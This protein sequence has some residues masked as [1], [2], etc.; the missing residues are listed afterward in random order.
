LVLKVVTKIMMK[1]LANMKEALDEAG[2]LPFNNCYQQFLYLRGMDG[3]D[4]VWNEKLGG[5]CIYSARVLKGMLE[6]IPGC[7]AD[8]LCSRTE[9][10]SGKPAAHI[11]VVAEFDGKQYLMD[12]F[13]MHEEPLC[14]TDVLE[15]GH[16]AGSRAQ[17]SFNGQKT[18]IALTPHFGEGLKKEFLLMRGCPSEK[19]ETEMDVMYQFHMDD[20]GAFGYEDGDEALALS[21]PG[22]CIQRVRIGDRVLNVCFKTREDELWGEVFDISY[23]STEVMRGGR[24]I[25]VFN[26]HVMDSV[27]EALGVTDEEIR[28]SFQ[29]G[30]DVVNA[31][32]PGFGS[33]MGRLDE[34]LSELRALEE[35]DYVTRRSSPL[36]ETPSVEPSPAE[37][38]ERLGRSESVMGGWAKRLF[39]GR[40][41]KK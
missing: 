3:G 30:S 19:G 17:P 41:R 27:A 8:L 12:P 25:E 39:G 33:A 4:E 2:K 20:V 14:L 18:E 31:R 28:E 23:P 16:N 36:I 29:A 6:T 22:V 15:C 5:D 40:F 11:V 1:G 21:M 35:S 13:M 38:V 37:P 24:T 9:V 34:L 10:F 26:A 7:R 32:L